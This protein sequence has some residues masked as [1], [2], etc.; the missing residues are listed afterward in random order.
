MDQAE[1]LF[2]AFD[3]VEDPRLDRRM[4]HPLAEILFLVLSA[5][6][7][8]VQTWCGVEEF[9][10][11]RIEWLR[12]YYPYKE[13]IPSHDT[14]GRVMSLLKPG[15]LV[16][17]YAQFMSA[18]FDVPEGEIIALDGKTLRR[19]FDKASGQKP[20]HILNAW[21]VK[22]GLAL[23]QLQVDEKTNEITALPDLLDMIDVKHATITVDALNT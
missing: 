21:A 8:G 19:Y 18:L 12:K 7:C 23:G 11:D 10:N 13:G 6:I 16:K 3:N 9:G 20:L 5:I 15:S 14:I 2:V 1:T 4:Q 22:S 17:A